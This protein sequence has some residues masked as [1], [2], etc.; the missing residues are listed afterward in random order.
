[1]DPADA[2]W[3]ANSGRKSFSCRVTAVGASVAQIREELRSRSVTTPDRAAPP[4]VA[5]LFTGQGSQYPGMGRPLYESQ[6]VF[7]DALERCDAALRPFLP[8]PLLDVLYPKS[9]ACDPEAIHRT[10]YT[11]PAL[12]AV[13]YA[14]AE[15]WRSWGIVPDAVMGHSVGEYVAACVSGVMSLEEGLGLIA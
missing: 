15:L 4:R 9:E 10:E 6:R 3:T 11:Q 13:E 2:C 7:R 8:Q 12:F 14:L 5:F 1:M